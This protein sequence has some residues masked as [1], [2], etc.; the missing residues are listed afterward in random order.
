MVQNVLEVVVLVVLLAIS[1]PLLGSYMAK[2]FEHQKAPGDRFFGRIERSAYRITGV[3]PEGEQR[4]TVYALSVLAFSLVSVI[5]LYGMQRLQAHLPVNPDH[6]AAVPP[7]LSFNTAASFLT[8]TN[9]QNY[10]GES[11]LS[12]FT[13][14]AGLA[15]EMFT[16]AAVGIAVAAAF[17]RGLTRDRTST[18]GNFWVDLVRIVTR[19]LLPIAF[20]FAIV[21]VSQGAVQNFHAARAVTTVAGGSQSIPGGPVASMEAIKQL[22]TNGGGYFNANS[23]HPFESPNGLTNLLEIWLLLAIPFALGWT[24][25][26]MARD[27]KKGLAVLGV[28]AGLWLIGALIVMPLEAGGNVHIGQARVSQ[29]I[30][31]NSP[32]GNMEGKEVRNGP[33]LS[34]L[35][36]ASSTGTST[37]SADSAYDSFTPLGGGVLLFNMMLGEVSPGGVGSGIYSILILALLTVFIAG[38]MVGRTPEFLGKK[39]QASE[40]KLVVLFL[41]FVPATILTFTAISVVM[42]SSLASISNP[43]P[44]G[45]TEVTYAFTSAANNNGSA[46]AGL[47]G[48]TDWYNTTLG[49]SM[50]IGRFALIVPALAIAG[51]MG[52]KQ[53]VPE[54]AGTLRTGTPLFAVMLGGITVIVVGLT[55]FPVLSLGPVV[56]QLAGKF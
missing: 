49:I 16:S 36:A 15:V 13:K 40:M 50:L 7:A 43:G 23:A 26:K 48:N 28:M 18:L 24:F 55:Y 6:L 4:W 35:F 56:E 8:N 11:T 46:F 37:G 52:R 21:F 32:G 2:I 14:M 22:G 30:T 25:G 27:R 41:L 34:G 31:A 39:V 1:T 33:I 17:I 45:L 3:D 5:V 53:R 38:L 42:H 44:H 51:S 19:I 54:S 47:N 20:V 29:A 12:Q 9:W 10:A